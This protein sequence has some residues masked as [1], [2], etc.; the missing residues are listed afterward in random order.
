M[1]MIGD[2]SYRG[3]CCTKQ[4]ITTSVGTGP[5]ESGRRRP[6]DEEGTSNRVLPVRTDQ[7]AVPAVRSCIIMEER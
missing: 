4:T 5:A 7:Q 3:E 1:A 6:V 2:P